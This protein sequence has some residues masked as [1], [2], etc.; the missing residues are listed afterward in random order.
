MLKVLIRWG[1][2][3][4]RTKAAAPVNNFYPQK[5]K[6]KKKRRKKKKNIAVLLGGRIGLSRFLRKILP[7]ACGSVEIFSQ[8]P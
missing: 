1:I 5:K 7:G 8:N 6:K 3:W 4:L 2:K